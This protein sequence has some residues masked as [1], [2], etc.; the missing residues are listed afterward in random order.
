MMIAYTPEDLEQLNSFLRGELSAVES[1]QR[2]LERFGD[3]STAA[4]F[5][6]LKD[7]HETRVRLLA[8]RI[9]RLGGKPA[10]GSGAWGGVVKWIE[11]GAARLGDR[12]LGDALERGERHGQ[13]DYL[14]DMR[15]LSPDTRRFVADRVL[16][17]QQRSLARV[18]QLKAQVAAQ[19][20]S[21][22]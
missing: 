18:R 12:A 6:D 19:E 16:P 4:E 14:R 8:E 17:E 1:Y 7:S 9:A 11:K 15:R 20:S 21:A 10:T 2:C 22:D 3:S 13:A 5:R